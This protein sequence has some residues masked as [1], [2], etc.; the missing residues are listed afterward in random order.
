VLIGDEGGTT[1]PTTDEQVRELGRRWA[2]AEQRGD[3]AVLDALTTDDF[4]LVG[5]AG[6]VLNKQQWLDRYRTGAL[7]TASL[8]WEEVEVRDYGTAA[9]ALGSITQQAAYQGHPVDGRFRATHIAVQQGD[10]R[11][12]AGLHLSPIAGP[13]PLPPQ[14]QPPQAAAR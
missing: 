12:L 5:P 2:E 1:M 4:A 11:L 9:I 13:P 14:G 3:V 8:A 7:V 6:F 10:R